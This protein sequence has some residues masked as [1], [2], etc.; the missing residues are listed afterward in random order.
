MHRQSRE[1]LKAF[2]LLL[3]EGGRGRDGTEELLQLRCD[4]Q[5]WRNQAGWW[6][7]GTQLWV[8]NA[9]YMDAHWEARHD[10]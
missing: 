7:G 6:W 8:T 1:S 9:N 2:R 4:P 10:Y 3:L 5:N